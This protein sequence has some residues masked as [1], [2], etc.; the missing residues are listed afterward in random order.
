MR[1]GEWA[2]TVV[3][4]PWW[5]EAREIQENDDVE[6]TP[7]RALEAYRAKELLEGDHA[8]GIPHP[9]YPLF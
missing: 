2:T 3:R 7:H 1:G 8:E 9:P 6:E 5:E 4:V